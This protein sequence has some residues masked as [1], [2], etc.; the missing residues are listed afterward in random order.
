GSGLE[1]SPDV[2]IDK[3]HVIFGL[4]YPSHRIWELDELGPCVLRD[5]LRQV[6]RVHEFTHDEL[7]PVTA[8]HLLQ[9]SDMAGCGVYTG[10][11]LN[12]PHGLHAE[13]LGK[14]YHIGVVAHELHPS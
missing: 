11:D 8:H 1:H 4:R 10:A 9:L 7:H 2:V 13:A 14:V 12:S 6:S 5:R 3:T